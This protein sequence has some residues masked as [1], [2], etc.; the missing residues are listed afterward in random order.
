MYCLC[1][2]VG[3][4]GV[5]SSWFSFYLNIS[6]INIKYTDSIS[7]EQ[8]DT[9]TVCLLRVDVPF[10]LIE[11]LIN[12]YWSKRWS[13]CQTILILFCQAFY[14]D[15]RISPSNFVMLHVVANVF[16]IFNS[17][18]KVINWYLFFEIISDMRMKL[19]NLN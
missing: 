18:S 10:F 14:S 15:V 11:K 9:S 1:I 8:N 3:V 13:N 4:F 6:C 17:L 12:V 16:Y 7:H 2:C 19:Y 5:F